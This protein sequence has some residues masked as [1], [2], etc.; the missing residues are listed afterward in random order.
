M[1]NVTGKREDARA[2]TRAALQKAVCGCGP[3]LSR[4]EAKKMLDAFFDEV[5]EALVRSEPVKLPSFGNFNVRSR[6]ERIGRNPRT[7]VEVPIAPRK[8]L[9]FKASPALLARINRETINDEE[10]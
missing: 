4:A 2:L 6:R 1:N 8:A 10:E 5:T 9:T 7:G 3:S